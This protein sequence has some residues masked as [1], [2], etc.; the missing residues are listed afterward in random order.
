MAPT[1][2]GTIV[3]GGSSR[4]TL[5][6]GNQRI[7]RERPSDNPLDATKLTEPDK[8]DEHKIACDDFIE[9]YPPSA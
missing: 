8:K 9:V 6:A 7:V 1:K 4:R 3:V 5:R 2:Q